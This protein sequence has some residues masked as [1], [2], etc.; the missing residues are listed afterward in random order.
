MGCIFLGFGK[1]LVLTTPHFVQDEKKFQRGY[2][3][4]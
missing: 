4:S 2:F 3:V 1:N